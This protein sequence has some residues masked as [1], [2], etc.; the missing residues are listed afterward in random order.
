MQT[1]IRTRLTLITLAV[2][3]IGMGLAAILSWLSVERLF[4]DTQRENLLTQ[5]RLSAAAL[6]GQPLS[7][8]EQPYT[9]TTNETPCQASTRTC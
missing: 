2:L 8:S 9:Q 1:P 5:A 3:L 6:Q 7:A 4:L